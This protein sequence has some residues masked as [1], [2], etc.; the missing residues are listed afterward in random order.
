MI[1]I[2]VVWKRLAVT[3]YS[4]VSSSKTCKVVRQAAIEMKDRLVQVLV[5]MLLGSPACFSQSI[6][7]NEIKPQFGAVEVDNV[8]ER[9]IIS[10][11]NASDAPL[12]IVEIRTTQ[13]FEQSNLCPIWLAEGSGCLI[14]ITF[15]PRAAGLRSGQ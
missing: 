10:I 15:T 3:L 11:F 14:N 12:Y 5:L 1:T 13:E 7:F 4:S 6:S 9:K 2:G 8:S